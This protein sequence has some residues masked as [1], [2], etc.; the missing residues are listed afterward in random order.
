VRLQQR[1]WLER[2]SNAVRTAQ[3]SLESFVTLEMLLEEQKVA[4]SLEIA[5]TNS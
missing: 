4:A 5:D 3:E 1:D 2:Y